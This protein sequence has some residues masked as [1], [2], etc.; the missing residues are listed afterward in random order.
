MRIEPYAQAVWQRVDRDGF[1]EAGDALSQLAVGRYEATG[2]RLLAGVKLG[3]AAQDPLAA[4]VTYRLGAAVG[5][6][7]GDSLNPVLDAT[8]A[9]ASYQLQAPTMGRTLLKLDA[10][11]TLRLGK[12][13][14]LYGG[15]ESATGHDRAGYGVNAGV[16]V[17]F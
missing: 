6:D 9:G 2:T 8:L 14:Y 11:G 1:A 10:S 4:S 3:S 15:L 12:Q 13:T 7:F 17:Q 5:R 16:R